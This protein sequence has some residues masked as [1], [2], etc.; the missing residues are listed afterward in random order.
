MSAPRLA[1]P[2]GRAGKLWLEQ[3]LRVAHRA[4]G[5]LDRKL[6]ILVTE[7]ERLRAESERTR[8]AW[9]SLCTSAERWL[10]RA[11]LL[12]GEQAIGPQEAEGEADVTISYT[13]TMG[14]RHPSGGSCVTAGQDDWEGAT[15]AAARQACCA[16]L[17]AAIEHA[18][19]RAA[20]AVVLAEAD[21]TRYRLRAVRD[22][23]I[24]RLEEALAQAKFALEEFERADA[25][26][27]RRAA[28]A[29]SH[30]R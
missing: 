11:V 19:A 24:P 4:A 20:L 14:A 28:L 6:Q 18:T 22:R 25:A 13:I 15:V 3:R 1:A 26:R 10:L 7:L 30:V 27:L 16:A 5:L 21:T 23:W 9:E 17:A 2:P 8:L 12:G 29:L